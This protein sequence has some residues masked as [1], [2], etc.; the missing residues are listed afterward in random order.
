MHC[1]GCI[2]PIIGLPC[3]RSL[4]R[5]VVCGCLLFV[6]SVCAFACVSFFFFFFFLSLLCLFLAT[7]SFADFLSVSSVCFPCFFPEIVSGLIWFSSVYLVTTARFVAD[8]LM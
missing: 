8:Q 2:T 7:M 6:S 3:L 4:L 5:S 1:L